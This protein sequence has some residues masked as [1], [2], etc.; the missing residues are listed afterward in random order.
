MEY[1]KMYRV[2]QRFDA[3]SIEDVAATIRDEF[4][5]F[6][7]S[8]S[9]PS[10]GKVAVAVG[11]RGI[12]HLPAIVATVVECLRGM[13]FSPYIIPAMGSHGAATGEGQ[14]EVLA[15]LGISEPS[16]GAPVVSNIDAISLG[17][18]ESGAEV[19][20]AK[21]AMDADYVVVISR[22]KPHTA[23]RGPVESGLCK[24]LAV[25]CGKQKGASNMHK[26]DLGSTIVPAARLIIEKAGVLCGLAITENASGGTHSIR[27]ARPEEFVD[28]DGALLKE[29]WEL[30]PRIPIQDLDIL[31]VNEMGKDISGAGM[32]PNVV[33]FWRRSGGPRN[34]DYRTII[35]LDLTPQ[36]HGNATGIGLADM[37][38]QTLMDKLDLKATYM[39]ALT[40]GILRSAV[41]PIA[42]ESDK[43]AIETV[44]DK[45]PDSQGV[46][47]ARIQ[48]TLSLGTFWVTEPLLGELGAIDGVSV[49]QTPLALRFDDQGRLMPL[50]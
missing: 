32:D 12:H 10:G 19:F 50:P 41:L 34:P 23:F 16:I 8:A 29:A 28:V 20:C 44:L 9:I 42:L 45:V 14:A 40:A 43:V 22:V 21:D 18:V 17:R 39:N 47:M 1:P 24:L 30:L 26:Y 33:G 4:E 6:K 11:S 7:T 25:G 48:N 37:T 15:E 27:L 13:G 31:I 5:R 2:E 36:S 49:D 46:R 38:T 35:V 3:P